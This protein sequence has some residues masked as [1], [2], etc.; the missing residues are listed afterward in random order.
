LIPLTKQAAKLGVGVALEV[1][2][3]VGVDVGVG[4]TQG[5]NVYVREAFARGGKWAVSQKSSVKKPGG[6][7][8]PPTHR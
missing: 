2:V 1:A 7:C 4:D 8:T 3:A 6:P 5:T